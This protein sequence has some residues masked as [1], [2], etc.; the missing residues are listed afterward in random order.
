MYN[1]I[2]K[3]SR[4]LDLGAVLVMLGGVQAAL[5]AL[6]GPFKISPE[7]TGSVTAAIGLVVIYLRFKTTTPVG[8][9]AVNRVKGGV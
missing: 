1:G 4:T 3:G 5:P 7:I 2:I 6:L 9:K 8:E